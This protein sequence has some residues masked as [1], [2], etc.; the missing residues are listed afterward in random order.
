VTRLVHQLLSHFYREYVAC[1]WAE[2]NPSHLRSWTFNQSSSFRPW[3]GGIAAR[4][5]C[6]NSKVRRCL[7]KKQRNA[8]GRP[9][10][11]HCCELSP[12]EQILI[13]PKPLGQIRADHRD[14]GMVAAKQTVHSMRSVCGA[15]ACLSSFGYGC[16]QNPQDLQIDHP[17]FGL[18]KAVVTVGRCATH[19]ARMGVAHG[20]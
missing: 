13:Q 6:R 15:T 9:S 1:L 14:V 10:M 16:P 20:A 8:L 18:L 2:F 11:H 4:C 19:T 12:C 3:N 5:T 17:R 7:G